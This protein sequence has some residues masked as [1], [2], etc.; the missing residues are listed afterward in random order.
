MAKGFH[1]VAKVDVFHCYGGS[2]L[3]HGWV[4][5][6][7]KFFPSMVDISDHGKN[8]KFVLVKYLR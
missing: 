5:E 3:L 6:V 4:D 8:H 2:P 7:V 1:Y